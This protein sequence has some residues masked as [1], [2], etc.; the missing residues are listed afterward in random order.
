MLYIPYAASSHDKTG[1]IITFAQ[2]E[3]GN[4][5]ENKRNSEENKLILASIDESSTGEDSDGGSI[6]MNVI[7]A[8]RDESQ[9]NPYL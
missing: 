9:I 1:D 5:L 3:E 8:I 7:E 4:L 6:S 2:Y